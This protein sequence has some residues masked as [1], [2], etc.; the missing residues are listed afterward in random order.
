MT[1]M[2]TLVNNSDATNPR[3][4]NNDKTSNNNLHVI[5]YGY[6]LQNFEITTEDVL[7][8]FNNI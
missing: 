1:S 3:Y 6:I 7:N 8:A 5:H 4:D 2:D